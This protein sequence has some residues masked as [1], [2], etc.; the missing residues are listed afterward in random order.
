MTL[1]RSRYSL[2]N[3]TA[4]LA[5]GIL[6]TLYWTTLYSTKKLPTSGQLG[7]LRNVNTKT[8]SFGGIKQNLTLKMSPLKEQ[9][10]SI[11]S[12][13]TNACNLKKILVQLQARLTLG[14]PEIQAKYLA[15]K[16]QLRLLDLK[17]LEALKLRTKARF[18][19]EGEK[20]L[21]ISSPWKNT[22]R[23]LN[24]SKRFKMETLTF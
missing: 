15:G 17:D 23:P 8:S 22:V 10:Y 1:S 19:E 16:E 4:A 21:E 5:C 3:L 12:P 24:S 14:S 9:H 13:T 11:N 18:L 2:Q 20:V 6:T 7:L